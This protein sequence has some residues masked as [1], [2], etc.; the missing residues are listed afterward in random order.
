MSATWPMRQ[1]GRDGTRFLPVIQA[2]ADEV[3]NPVRHLHL[4]PRTHSSR[5]RERP[6]D[7]QTHRP[8]RSLIN[9]L[10][11]PNF[12]DKRVIIVMKQDVQRR[13]HTNQIAPA[14]ALFDLNQQTLIV[15]TQLLRI[16]S[17]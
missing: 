6:Q 11:G 9:P 5:Y 10:S 12:N 1:E 2:A 3:E 17:L 4:L 14:A 15:G 13:G 8:D 16:E 7:D